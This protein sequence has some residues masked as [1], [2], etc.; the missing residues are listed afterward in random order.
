L[1]ILCF[2]AIVQG[3]KVKYY[4]LGPDFI[5]VFL[6][7]IKRVADG[8]ATTMDDFAVCLMP[9]VGNRGNEGDTHRRRG[10]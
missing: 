3:G 7:R 2:L 5:F 1:Y 6:A 8:E 4:G 10:I 9:P